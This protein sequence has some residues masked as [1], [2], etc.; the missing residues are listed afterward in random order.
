MKLAIF[1]D[2]FLPQINGI[3]THLMETLP[4]IAKNNTL[5][6]AVPKPRGK[7]ELP[8]SFSNIEIVYLSGLPVFFYKD[9]QITLPISPFLY[10]QLDKFHPDVIHFHSAFTTGHNGVFYA[11][12]KKIPLVG[13]FHGYFMEPEYLSIIG[14]DKIGLHRSK[15]L[16]KLLWRYSNFFYNKADMVICPSQATR[17]DLI[18]H[19][20]IKPVHAVSNGIKINTTAK[21]NKTY[22]LPRKYFLYVGRIS[23]EK[24]LD[25]LI[26]ALEKTE[27]TINLVMV[28]DGPMKTTLENMT[29]NKKL[30]KR[31]FLLGQIDHDKLIC[32]NIYEDALG[33]I[34]ASTSETQ[35]I[36][37][38]EA[39]AA[40]L[41]IIGV[42]AR[43]LPELITD[44]GVIC[45]VGDI[46]SLS[47]AMMTIEG[48][49]DLRKKY[50][51]NSK[52]NVRQHSIDK[53][54]E[55]LEKIYA[56]VSGA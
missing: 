3:V 54:I 21:R 44:N 9:W 22:Q 38:L 26:Q 51:D 31:V 41:P 5:L 23:K 15:M 36:T 28:G 4:L 49:L 11:R 34:T 39:M 46:D 16:N 17:K 48:N 43:A 8:Q 1:S 12:Q 24:N 14:L 37:I 35:G 50:G 18:D 56:S 42:K 47:N 45:N 55:R 2:A 30:V 53:T 33:F 32:S 27:T 25:L 19:G 29:K 6:L 52:N 20:V 40:G 13:T 7:I 10:R